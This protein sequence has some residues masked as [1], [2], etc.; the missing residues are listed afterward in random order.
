M[1]VAP[2]RTNELPLRRE[3]RAGRKKEIGREAAA[4]SLESFHPNSA[5]RKKSRRTRKPDTAKSWDA[6]EAAV[7]CLAAAM[8]QN[9]R[10]RIEN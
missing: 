7:K 2:G 6:S 8:I 3:S 1:S 10:F 4:I 9:I 5:N